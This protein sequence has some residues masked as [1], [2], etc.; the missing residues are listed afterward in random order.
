M[1]ANEDL[2]E[3]YGVTTGNFNK[4]VMRNLQRF[5]EDFAFRLTTE[6]FKNLIFQIGTSRS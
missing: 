1:E 4:S 6:E 5:P 3:L 2:A